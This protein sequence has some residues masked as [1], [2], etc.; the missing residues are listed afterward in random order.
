MAAVLPAWCPEVKGKGCSALVL[1]SVPS[2]EAESKAWS[3]CFSYQEISCP[4]G[5]GQQRCRFSMGQVPFFSGKDIFIFHFSGKEQ[6]QF[7]CRDLILNL[8]SV[9]RLAQAIA[10]GNRL[11]YGKEYNEKLVLVRAVTISRRLW[12]N[13]AKGKQ[14]TGKNPLLA[15]ITPYVICTYKSVACI[16]SRCHGG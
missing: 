16:Q 4:L 7:L 5:K 13:T 11:V 12:R 6:R 2:E 9:P 15:K 10:L 8:S 3:L 1:P 14:S